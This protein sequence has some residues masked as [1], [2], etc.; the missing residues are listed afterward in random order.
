MPQVLLRFMGI[1]SENELGRS[2]RVA[3]IW[4]VISMAAAVFIGV[5]G[6]SVAGL[7]YLSNNDAENIFIDAATILPAADARGLRLR[8]RAGRGDLVLRFVSADRSQR[9]QPEPVSQRVQEGRDG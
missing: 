1:R 9:R 6:R 2:R 4:V 3:I 8:G 5:V 7:D